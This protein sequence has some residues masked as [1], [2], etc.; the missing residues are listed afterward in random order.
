MDLTF[1]AL[2]Q[3]LA[4]LGWWMVGEDQL[5]FLTVLLVGEPSRCQSLVYCVAF[6]YTGFGPIPVDEIGVY[7]D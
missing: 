7:Q 2:T 4:M 3:F 5:L 6:S 1:L